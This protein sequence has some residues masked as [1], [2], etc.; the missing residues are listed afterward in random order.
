MSLKE[1]N[2]FF[3]GQLTED[4]YVNIEQRVLEKTEYLKMALQRFALI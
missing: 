3:G 1:H 2:L 4:N